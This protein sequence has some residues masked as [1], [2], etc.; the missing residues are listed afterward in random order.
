MGSYKRPHAF[1]PLDLETIDLVYQAAWAHIIARD[2]FRD[3]NK[4]PERKEV[5]RKMIF[6]VAR[7]GAINFDTLL[8]KVLWFSPEMWVAFTKPRWRALSS[9]E[10][11]AQLLGLPGPLEPISAD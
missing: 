1:T 11:S 5:L 7:P 8:D 4:D 10:G 2:Q 3:I 9:R 6:A